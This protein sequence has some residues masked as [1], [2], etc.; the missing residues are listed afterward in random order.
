[1][2][3]VKA[4]DA[5]LGLL[6]EFRRRGF[7]TTLVAPLTPFESSLQDVSQTLAFAIPTF[8]DD[9]VKKHTTRADVVIVRNLHSGE[10]DDFTLFENSKT[11]SRIMAAQIPMLDFPRLKTGIVAA[12]ERVP[13]THFTQA[14]TSPTLS[15]ADRKR[16]HQWVLASIAALK[17]HQKLFGFPAD[18]DV[19]AAYEA[20]LRQEQEVVA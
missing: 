12:M 19:G 14:Y 16:A 20:M 5:E 4:L 11:K 1:L 6:E 8:L 17:P 7:A 13:V 2:R 3:G 10:F 15:I 9:S 18:L